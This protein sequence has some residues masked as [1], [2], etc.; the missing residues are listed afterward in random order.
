MV[1]V[2]K[3]FYFIDHRGSGRLFFAENKKEKK[4]EKKNKKTKKKQKKTKQKQKK[5]NNKK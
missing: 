3:R 1:M 4:K 5:N 2:L